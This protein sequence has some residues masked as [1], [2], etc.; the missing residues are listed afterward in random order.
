MKQAII[1]FLKSQ[2]QDKPA[3][4]GLSGGVDSAV[5]AALLVQAVPPS[6]VY[7]YYLPSESNAP[8][9]LHDSKQLAK[10]LGIHYETIPIDPLVAAYQ[11]QLGTLSQ[12]GLGNL[13]AR[14]RMTILYAQANQLGGLVVGTGNKTELQLGYFTKYGDGGVDLLP[15]AHLYKTE[16]WALAKTLDIPQSIISKP[17]TAGLWPGQTDEQELGISYAV[18]DQILQAIEQQQALDQFDAALVQLVQHRRQQ[19][20]HKLQPVARL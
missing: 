7:S 12:M 20:Q 6:Q 9:D 8:S 11:A 2:L 3:I 18:A 14:I 15:I 10:Q 13:K 1:D 16:V 5:V 4:L 19:A 17:P